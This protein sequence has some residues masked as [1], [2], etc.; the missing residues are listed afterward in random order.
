MTNSTPSPIATTART[1]TRIGVGDPT[2]GADPVVLLHVEPDARSA[3][4]FATFA[5]QFTEGFTV[6]SVDGMGPALDAA[7]DIDC[8]VTEQRLPNA[9]GVD[10]VERL[11]NR[12]VDAP[13]VFHTTCREDETGAQALAAGADAYFPKRPERGQYNRILDRLRELVDDAPG[14]DTATR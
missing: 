14:A 4:L 3:E 6:R 12:G 5:E 13:I 7:D 2:E 8:V 11:R 1:D 9:S 10:L